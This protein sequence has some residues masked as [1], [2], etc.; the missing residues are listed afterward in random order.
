[1]K[2]LENTAPERSFEELFVDLQLSKVL[3]DDKQIS[4]AIPLDKPSVI[5]QK[6]RA[7]KKAD[8][9]DIKT[10]FKENFEITKTPTSGFEVDTKRSVEEHIKALWPFLQR[11]A[12]QLIDGSSLIPLQYPYIVP[13]GRFNEIYYWDSFFTML[14]L[15]IHGEVDAIETMVKNFAWMINTIGFIPNGNRTYFL[16][17]SQP[18]FFSLMVCLLANIKGDSILSD[19]LKELELE[20]DFWMNAEGASE[21]HLVS[22]K[23]IA[24]NR[25]YDRNEGPRPEMYATDV[26]DYEKFGK[27]ENYYKHLRAACESGWDFSCRWFKDPMD[28]GSINTLNILPVDLNCLLLYLERTIARAYEYNDNSQQTEAWNKRAS[29]REEAIQTLF[30]N[31]EQKFFNDINYKEDQH[32]AVLS[33]AGLFPLFFRCA[34]K[35]QAKACAKVV[36]QHFLKEGGLVSTSITTGQQ[37]DAPNGWAP[38]QY[39][40]V[41]GLRNYG[42]DELANKIIS[43]WIQSNRAIYEKTGKMLEK[44]NVVDTDQLSGGGEYLVQDGFGWTNGVYLAFIRLQ[45]ELIRT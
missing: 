12:D 43:R 39:M 19:Y 18:P 16:G 13:G 14:G 24:I 8:D 42:F 17:R 45:K 15:K 20:Y 4:D 40:S 36:E 30:W 33:L 37:W 7:Q 21:S 34:T 22:Y 3:T 31:P 11:E 25:Y 6:Y 41:I 26:A 27:P 35:K 9:F 10:F 2:E 1:M 28:L 44:Y 38:L 29:I 32:T 23:G 5:L